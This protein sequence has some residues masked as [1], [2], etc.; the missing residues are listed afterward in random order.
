MDAP[1]LDTLKSSAT[2]A[3]QNAV[4][5][6]AS[7]N[8]VVSYS[9][10]GA[11]YS[12]FQS[13][14]NQ[15][16][17]LSNYSN[18]LMQR[19]LSFGAFNSFV[20]NWDQSFPYNLLVLK[21]NQ[22]GD[23]YSIVA[24]YTLPINPQSLRIT[25]PFASKLTITSNGVL[26]EHNGTPI[27]QIAIQATTGIIPQRPAY[28]LASQPGV[29]GTLFGGTI[30]AAQSVIASASNVISS[31]S[32]ATS[33]AGQLSQTA[34]YQSGY[35]Q[36]HLLRMFL[37][38]YAEAKKSPNNQALRLA[39]EIPKDG[40]TY[41]ITPQSF[42]V[43]R[44]ANAP[45]EYVFSFNA[46]AWGT[47]NS[48]GLSN[49]KATSILTP[50][51]GNTNILVNALN[52][53]NNARQTVQ[54]AQN[55]VAAVNSDIQNNI[56]GP[57]NQVI[58]FAKDLTGLATAIADL[59]G[60]ISKS[61]SNNLLTN[62]SAISASFTNQPD[63]KA[64][65][66][67]AVSNTLNDS[68]NTGGSFV[69]NQVG[70]QALINN[71]TF[72][73]AL[74][75]SSIPLSASQTQAI[76]AVQQNAINN[77]NQNFI[78]KLADNLQSTADSLANAAPN[79]VIDDDTFDILYSLQQT[80]VALASLTVTDSLD[81]SQ[82]VN[83]L[84]FWDTASQ[85]NNIPFTV[86]NSKFSVP[87]PYNGTLEWVAQTYLGDATRWIEIAALNGLQAPYIDQTG[88]TVQL[89]NNGSNAEFNIADI[90]NLY[91][92]QK[93]FLSSNTQP[94][95]QFQI[96][97][98]SEINS[99]NFIITVQGV[100]VDLS[101]YKLSDEAELLAYLP[102]TVNSTSTLYIPSADPAQIDGL[103]TKP[104]SYI[105]T[106]PEQL[107]FS[108]I[109]FLLDSNGDLAIGPNGFANLAF[110]VTNLT[111]AAKL[112]VTTN[113]NSLLGHPGFGLGISL[114]DSEADVTASDILKNLNNTFST[115]ARFRAI[116]N[117]SLQQGDTYL[118][119]T[120]VA[121][122]ANNQGTL[123]ISFNLSPT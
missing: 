69:N 72:A 88:F 67:A 70:L 13:A 110:G 2:A 22:G 106:D 61:L 100:A 63:L 82:A 45:M 53:L 8:Q 116:E 108:K 118:A 119:L 101:I 49:I 15:I 68:S 3:V 113:I 111:Q 73:A 18:S 99:T 90:T 96:A 40:I 92:G 120:I 102:Y 33:T 12:V 19:G 54:L 122:L 48:V 97:A 103:T 10:Q 43:D 71:P 31:F 17:D 89:L 64:Q 5:V 80:I 47:T 112:K 59:P 28:N 6:A 86:P 23:N 14:M 109:D 74:P 42:S 81:E 56:I 107:A 1:S 34:I 123:P 85:A 30:A 11:D 29:L 20:N 51:I 117:F 27:R 83:P 55:T 79:G 46:T 105:T 32:T 24:S 4:G 114:G 62:S 36:F 115:D 93:I 9:N 65:F 78:N 21:S 58:L 26:E 77:T 50:G 76:Q 91:V 57:L 104:I 60:N 121:Q 52:A 7:G 35:F 95:T 44:S 75:L 16:I 66:D 98:I 37:E 84:Q 87:F 38:A 94:R 41:L 39:L 25:T